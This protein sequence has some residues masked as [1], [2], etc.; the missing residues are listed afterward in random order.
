M[1]RVMISSQRGDGKMVPVGREYVR[2][3][4]AFE[5]AARVAMYQ[6]HRVVKVWEYRGPGESEMHLV[7][8]V[9]APPVNKQTSEDA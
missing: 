4:A 9:A 7:N 8:P 6:P 2:R 3:H 1:F 5:K